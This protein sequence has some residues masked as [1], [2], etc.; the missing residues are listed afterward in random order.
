MP[1]GRGGGKRI[2][3]RGV[4]RVLKTF[5]EL[6][7]GGIAM[8][9]ILMLSVLV[10]FLGLHLAGVPVSEVF[11]DGTETLGPPSISIASGS[12]I[13][14]AGTGLETQPGV[15]NISVPGNVKQVLLYWSGGSIMPDPGDNTIRVNG[16]LITGT[17]IGGPAP[18]YNNIQFSSFR[19]DITSLGLVNPGD[20]TFIIYDMNF[21]NNE[22]NGAGILVIYDNG[23]DIADIQVRDGIDLAFFNFPDPRKTT[24]PQTFSF[25]PASFD[26]TAAL[27]MFFG[28]VTLGQ[29]RPN[30]IAITF[31][32]GD[33]LTL[34][35]K[36][37]S[38]DGLQWDTLN[39]PVTI[40]AGASSLTVQAISTPSF[41]PLGAS[42][43]WIGASLSVST[44]PAGCRVTGGGNDTA[45]I[46]YDG[47]WDGTMAEDRFRK[48][49][50]RG[51]NRYTF[52]GQAGA[53]TGAQ[54][55]PSGEWTHH[56]QS[57]PYGSFIFHAGTASAPEGT[58]IAFIQCSDPGYCD[59]AREA[60]AKQIDF[61]G[62]GTFKNAKNLSGTLAGV[63]EGTTYHW[64]EVH[65][66]DLGEPGN[67]P[68]GI[69][70]KNLICTNSGSGTD[71]F[72]V[73]P[74]FL[75]GN[76]GCADFYRIRVY[77]GVIPVFDPFIGEITNLNKSNVI[78]EVWGYI[79]GGN[80]QIH[81]P[82]GFDLK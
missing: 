73:P 66:E 24:I 20:N 31:D 11:A 30:E 71:A 43:S 82:T 26:R 9:R 37:G 28:S 59:P 36:L 40:P 18:F 12:G 19:A 55:Q 74:V 78:Y 70:K 65:I 68:K 10:V 21:G 42:F 80:L 41:D 38:K 44:F 47:G 7:K 35:D 79:D 75:P 57:G 60:P 67:E 77:E 81:P 51:I 22:N 8:K 56:Q 33:G 16:E 64:F 69:E 6:V 32:V 53:R 27:S 45:G 52:G 39:E 48:N 23:S 1:S 29:P 50:I 15:I 62:V 3:N 58:E 25:A 49:N 17:L 63:I 2:S 34:F 54:P 61:A 4:V 14:A 5:L 13:I 46:A 72:A 76:C